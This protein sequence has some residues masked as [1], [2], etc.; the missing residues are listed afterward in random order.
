MRDSKLKTGELPNIKNMM[1][2]FRAKS[3]ERDQG[4]SKIAK[5]Q[6]QMQA[7]RQSWRDLG[8]S[9]GPNGCISQAVLVQFEA[10]GGKKKKRA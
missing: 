6:Q 10:L 1:S 9:R 7:L 8:T 5:T 4:N 2:K 3:N